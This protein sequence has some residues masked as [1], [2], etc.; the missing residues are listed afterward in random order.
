MSFH[1]VQ[2]P[3]DIAHGASGGPGFCTEILQMA[4]G[5]EE[6]HSRWSQARHSY[7]ISSGVKT[8]AQ[9]ALL[10]QFYMARLG[11]AYGFRYKD[12][13]DF[14]TASDG[15]SAPSDTDQIIGVADN[16]EK[17]FQLIKIYSSGGED[18]DRTITKPVSGTTV[19]A[20]NGVAQPAGWSIDITTGLV[21]FAVAPVTGNVTAGCEF[22]VPVR[23]DKS[24]DENWPA[25][26]DEDMVITQIVLTELMGA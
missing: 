22:D 20:V 8:P 15:V 13:L 25:S 5:A 14:T 19:V 11:A 6:R 4:G 24:I 16:S 23:F 17:E 7:D 9:Y 3:S 1:E 10:K 2:F 12:W 26:L 18:L 21:T